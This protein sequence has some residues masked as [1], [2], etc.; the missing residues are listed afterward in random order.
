MSNNI[1]NALDD[2]DK[3]IKE[4]KKDF[5][6]QMKEVHSSG[7]NNFHKRLIDLISKNPEDKE[8]LEFIV[9]VNDKI[10]TKIDNYFEIIN[11]IMLDSLK[12]KSNIISFLKNLELEEINKI[13]NIETTF[14]NNINKNQANNKPTMIQKIKKIDFHTLIYDVKSIIIALLLLFITILF[15]INP[16]K[17]D[18]VLQT[19]KQIIFKD[20]SKIAHLVDN[21]KSKTENEQ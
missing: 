13:K 15:I 9:L 2:L 16:K 11:Y 3:S 12:I 17:G 21:N 8:I 4:L 10:E 20:T 18:E 1:K 14:V 6:N 7:T 5:L 19:T